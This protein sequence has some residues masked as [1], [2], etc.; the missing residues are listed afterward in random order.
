MTPAQWM[1]LVFDLA[2]LAAIYLLVGLM[3]RRLARGDDPGRLLHRFRNGFLLLAIGD[4]GHVGFR[5]VAYLMG[6]LDSTVSVA[7]LRV[8]L[9]GPGALATA[10]TVT[11]LYMILLDFRRVRSGRGFT[12]SWW[13]L[14]AMGVVRFALLIPSANDWGATVPPEGWSLVRNAPLVV[15]GIGVAVL[16]LR[17]GLAG[18]DGTSVGIAVLI[19]L[20][21]AFYAP[22]ILFVRR[23]PMIGMLMIPKTL[24]YLAMAWLGCVR[25][26]VRGER[27]AR[28]AAVT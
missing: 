14:M 5:V 23:V 18:K 3:S 6:G 8:P 27:G 10:V 7:G 20:S 11:V 9:V 12:A 19:V 1:E 25:L 26:F 24:M 4:T 22:V 2:Y 15:L 17:D 13:L 28:P 21:Y 16:F